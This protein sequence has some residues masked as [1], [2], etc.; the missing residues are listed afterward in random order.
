[1][2]P[3]KKNYIKPILTWVFAV[4][5]FLAVSWSGD[6]YG[7]LL[8]WNST[9]LIVVPDVPDSYSSNY[10]SASGGTIQLSDWQ[11]HETQRTITIAISRPKPAPMETCP[12]EATG[13][14]APSCPMETGGDTLTEGTLP[15]ITEATDGSWASETTESEETA[16]EVTWPQ[17]E[18]VVTLDDV[19]SEHLTYVTWVSEEYIEILLE[20]REVADGLQQCTTL[21]VDIAWYDL[22]GTI[23]VNMLPY[24][25]VAGGDTEDDDD[26]REIVLGLNLVQF[27]DVMH[28]QKA[29]AHLKLNLETLSDFKLTFIQDQKAL[30][31]VWWSLD[32]ENFTLL[33]DAYE[34]TLTWPYNEG[35]DGFVYLD[36]SDALVGNQPPT[37]VVE[38]TG[39]PRQEFTP[40][41]AALPVIQNQIIK[42][43][44]LPY[45]IP[46]NAHWGAS[47]LQVS[48]IQRLVTDAEGN[49]VYMDDVSVTATVTSNGI[50]LTPVIKDVYP[51]LGSYRMIV[52]WIW[53]ETVVAKQIVYLFMNTN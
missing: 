33:Y 46:V 1:M 30:S 51:M 18:V 5:V 25:D 47:T 19:A 50:V 42:T 13:S 34:L 4:I 21:T 28:A 17:D 8:D 7:R 52:N 41:L 27:N 3:I 10:L 11:A 14:S 44:A 9:E 45:T 16:T 32:G 12:T 43:S 36:F 20:R 31:K 6:S 15:E 29:T 48:K 40:M 22:K 24:G 35:W 39:Y 38:A 23:C 49:M 2:K 26:H 37:I 53:N